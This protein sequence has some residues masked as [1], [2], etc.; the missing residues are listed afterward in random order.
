MEFDIPN[1]A[2]LDKTIPAFRLFN[3]QNE[4]YSFHKLKWLVT[5][6]SGLS[7]DFKKNILE[8]RKNILIISMDIQI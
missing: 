1:E 8:I 7:I 6:D 3:Q 4:D 2:E 5:N